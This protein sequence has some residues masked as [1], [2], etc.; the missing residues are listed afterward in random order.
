MSPKRSA[1]I[2]HYLRCWN[3]AEAARLAGYAE[4]SARQTAHE[5]LTKSDIQDAIAQRLADLQASAD[6]VLTRLTDHARGSMADFVDVSPLGEPVIN[7]TE[8]KT[9][10]KLHLLKKIKTTKKVSG[11]TVEKSVEIELYDAQSALVQL[12]RHHR[13]FVDRVEG[14]WEAELRAAGIDPREIEGDIV[15]IIKRRLE[16]RAAGADPARD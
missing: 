5:L 9:A 6:E 7:L 14:D 10:G 1:F 11:E 3:G 8:A 15:A 16:G 4:R 2:E 12:G 13:L